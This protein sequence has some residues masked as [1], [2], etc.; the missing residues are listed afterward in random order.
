MN[1]IY[2]VG[3]G[4]GREDM[5]TLQAVEALEKSDIIIGYKVYTDLLPDRFL[6]KEIINTPMKRERERCEI[7]YEKAIAGRTVSLVCSGD[8]G[9]YGMASLLLEVINNDNALE[10]EIVPGITAASSGAAVLGAPLSHD[11]CVISLSDLLTPIELIHKRIRMAAMGDF[12]IAIYNP[13]ST[14]RADYLKTVCEILLET[15]E[16]DRPCGYVENIGRENEQYTICTL[17]ELKDKNV[18]MFTTVF[19]GNSMTKVIGN[20]LV[21]PRGYH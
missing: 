8:A 14:K 21:T 4:P 12:C 5:M 18:N 16:S 7:A 10:V 20:K 2:V 13:S 9:I 19:V 3:M 15:I 17:G 11:F 1:K 6:T